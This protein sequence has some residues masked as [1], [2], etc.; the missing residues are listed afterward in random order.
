MKKPEIATAILSF[1]VRC[2]DEGNIENNPA[3]F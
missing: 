1:I 3:F 2:G